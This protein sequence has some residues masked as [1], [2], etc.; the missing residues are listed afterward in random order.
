MDHAELLRLANAASQGKRPYFFDN[1]DI[2]RL[3]T[4]VWAIAGEL[5]VARERID[6]LERVLARH[7]LLDRAEIESFSPSAEEA[8][9]RGRLQVEYIARLLRILQQ[10]ADTLARGASE[11]S[12]EQVAR[13]VARP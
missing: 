12:A 7:R 3:L 10:E 4:I 6:T 8:A 2:D 11:A 1:P 5:A 13:E 9:E